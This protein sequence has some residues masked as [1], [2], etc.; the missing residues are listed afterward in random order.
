MSKFSFVTVSVFFLLPSC[1]FYDM[2]VVDAVENRPYD[3]VINSHTNV[4]Y[5]Y[6][7]DGENCYFI[8]KCRGAI[9]LLAADA[10]SN[11]GKC[12]DG[13]SIPWE[14]RGSAFSEFGGL[15]IRIICNKRN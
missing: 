1:I 9:E 13:Y 7:D 14:N 11:S 6:M 4:L 5:R 12:P 3:Y 2:K 8:D 10:M 15:H